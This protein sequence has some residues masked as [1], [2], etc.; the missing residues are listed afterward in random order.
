M[1]LVLQMNSGAVVTGGT[2]IDALSLS[3][4]M[5]DVLQARHQRRHVAGCA[6]EWAEGAMLFDALFLAPA[7]SDVLQ[8]RLIFVAATCFYRSTALAWVACGT[9]S[10]ARC[11]GI[12]HV[13]R[14]AGA[15]R[16][17]VAVCYGNTQ[18]PA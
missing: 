13:E 11:V 17:L 14:A 12:H 16:A 10:A 4:T 3:S 18:E 2:L 6:A 15:P 1:P 5:P 8:V 9:R 7:V